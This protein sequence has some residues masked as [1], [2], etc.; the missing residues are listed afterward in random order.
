MTRADSFWTQWLS[1]LWVLVILCLWMPA[2]AEE[3]PP[4][5]P[6]HDRRMEW[7]RD[8][9][10]GM[11]I[12]FGLYSTAAG[13]WDGEPVGFVEYFGFRNPEDWETLLPKFN[14]EQFDADAIVSAAKD[15]GMK[16]LVI[17]SKHHDGFCLFDSEHTDFDVMSTPFKRDIVGELAEACRKQGLNFGFYYS[18]IDLNHP[19]YLPRPGFDPRPAEGADFERYVRFMKDQLRELLTNYGK[20]DVVWFDGEWESTWS[21]ERAKDMWDYIREIDP[22]VLINNRID[23]GRA[24]MQGMNTA[25]H[26]LGDFGTPE[27]E[28]L[29]RNP[30]EDWET[31][32]TMNRKGNWGWRKDEG[33]FYSKTELVR[34]VI[35]CASMGGNMLLNVG[36]KDDGTIPQT[37]LE[38]LEA[39]G[40]WM[41]VNAESIH[42]SQASPYDEPPEWG[43]ATVKGD[44]MYCHIYEWPE[45]GLLTLPPLAE[46]PVGAWAQGDPQRSPLKLEPTADGGARIDISQVAADPHATV[47]AVRFQ[48]QPT[49]AAAADAPAAAGEEGAMIDRKFHLV[50]EGAPACV[51]VTAVT[52]TPAARLAALELQSHILKMTG[53]EIP[54]QHEADA[55]GAPKILV[56]DTAATRALG[57]SPDDFEDQEYMIAFRDGNLIMIGKDWIDTPENRDAPG[58]QTL[59]QFRPRINYWHT[60]GFPDREPLEIE[61]PGLY[62]NHGTSHAAYH[63][64][65]YYCGVRWYGPTELFI[66]TPKQE[67][68]SVERKD[69]RRAP[70]LKHRNARYSGMWPFLRGQWGGFTQEPANLELLWRRMRLGGEPW[71]ANHTITQRSIPAAMNDPEI[72]AHG[73]AR[74]FGLCFTHPKAVEVVA[75]FARHYFDGGTDL[76]VDT[77]AVG[78][79]FAVV[80]EDV[81]YF[82]DCE[83]CQ[84]LLDK[85]DTAGDGLFASS[86][87]SE[88]W[89]SFVNA[90]AREVRE[91]HPDKWI[92]TLAYWNY[93]HPPKTFAMEPNVSVAPCLHVCEYPMNNAVRENDRA[94]YQGWQAATDAPMF[95]WNYYHLPMEAALIHGWKCFP[96][97][98]LRQTAAV[99]KRFAR[100]DVRGI[101]ICG[102]QDQL[103]YHVMVRLWDDPDLDVDAMVDEFFTL[104]FGGAAEPM[105]RFYH[106]IEQIVCDP[107][108]YPAGTVM[109]NADIAWSH[110]GTP[111]R[112]KQLG[113]LIQSAEAR[114]NDD[115]ERMRVSLWRQ[116]IWQWMLDGRAEYD[117][118]N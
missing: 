76:P 106:T 11:F 30:G 66:I 44:L 91:T 99:A 32:Q 97:I 113:A 35:D 25:P 46:A 14:P 105:K 70:A 73:Q 67:S 112:M 1:H 2:A 87:A 82:C 109:Q 8:A 86:R 96:H 18:I 114:A 49:A 42:G 4:A 45:N 53:V 61:L 78:D 117:A 107:K 110:L 83:S 24:G 95:M 118:R 80:P 41:A 17:T 77:I 98:M 19:D 116:A 115:T 3:T 31:C 74:G 16:Y 101:F 56:G 59:G 33:N 88:Y 102:E 108:N 69:V 55:V 81:W 43:T 36:P 50:R 29:E 34:Q 71:M 64:L 72:Q 27:Q 38:R 10:F 12:H 37:S 7:F 21:H 23:K 94:L 28:L 57:I 93:S 65:D 58:R 62:D 79:Y 9:R 22:D 40:K 90:V 6:D 100:D 63:F 26:F 39:I 20:I 60:A 104:Y 111:A 68:L 48:G 15:A 84:K 13:E 52:P 75:G 47:I 89:F 51:I 5:D 54:L 85:G 92:A 103:E